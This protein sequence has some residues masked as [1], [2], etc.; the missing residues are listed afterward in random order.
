MLVRKCDVCGSIY[1]PFSKD[2]NISCCA[3]DFFDPHREE[4]NRKDLCPGCTRKIKT[5]IFNEPEMRDPL[6]FI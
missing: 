1:D 5:K 4:K 3:I 2:S 6:S